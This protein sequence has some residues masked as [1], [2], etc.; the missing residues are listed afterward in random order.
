M[1]D[2]SNK[3]NSP[4]HAIRYLKS[5]DRVEKVDY[6]KRSIDV[7]VPNKLLAQHAY[8]YLAENG[9]I[10]NCRNSEDSKYRISIYNGGQ[11]F[12]SVGHLL[13]IKKPIYKSEN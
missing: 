7:N 5:N 9:W 13:Y 2:F 8:N 4:K 1:N 11:V 3:F 6:I 12:Y 10:V